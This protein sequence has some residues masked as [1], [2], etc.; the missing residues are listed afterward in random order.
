LLHQVVHVRTHRTDQYGRTLAKLSLG[1]DDVGDWM[2]RQGHA[3]S[4]HYRR[5]AGPYAA[6]ESLA[7]GANRGLFATPGAEQPRD[8]R[9]RHGS[10]HVGTP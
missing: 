1:N 2:V 7:Q 4:Y 3:W 10:C 6:Q 8:F 5:S 9:K